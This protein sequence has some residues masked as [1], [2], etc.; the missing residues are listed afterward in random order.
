MPAGQ[1]QQQ[2]QQPSTVTVIS[3]I[4]AVR[5][6]ATLTGYLHRQSIGLGII[7]IIIGTLS[8]V[9]NSIDFVVT[10]DSLQP[11]GYHSSVAVACH[12]L[13]GGVLVRN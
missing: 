7:L 11:L 9:F 1:Q 13:W 4:S 3:P 12:G 2:Q 5:P 8:A 6:P 10:V